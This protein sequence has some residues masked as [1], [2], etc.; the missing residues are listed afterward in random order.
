MTAFQG[1]SFDTLRPLQRGLL[2]LYLSSSSSADVTHSFAFLFLSLFFSFVFIFFFSGITVVLATGSK[3]GISTHSVPSESKSDAGGD[4]A[5]AYVCVYVHEEVNAHLW[6]STLM[7]SQQPS[8]WEMSVQIFV[9][10]KFDFLQ[11]TY[12]CFV[13]IGA[14]LDGSDFGFPR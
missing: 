2:R 9:H 10:T 6:S 11:F 3:S 12:R 13:G 7:Q 8:A 4:L 5:K 14:G 1:S